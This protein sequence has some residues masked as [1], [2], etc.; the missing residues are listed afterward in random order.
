MDGSKLSNLFGDQIF[1][2]CKSCN[3]A[4]RSFWSSSGFP[5]YDAVDLIHS[6]TPRHADMVSI[7]N[8]AIGQ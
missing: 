1:D 4:A 6:C 3:S 8:G 2:V 7:I 5:I